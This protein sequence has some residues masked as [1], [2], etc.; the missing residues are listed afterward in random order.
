M[1]FIYFFT[2]PTSAEFGGRVHFSNSVQ[3]EFAL[4]TSQDWIEIA[5]AFKCRPSLKPRALGRTYYPLGFA[6]L[7]IFFRS[8]FFFVLGTINCLR[9]V[10]PS[11]GSASQHSSSIVVPR[12]T[13]VL[14]SWRARGL[15]AVPVPSFTAYD[16]LIK[17]DCD[18]D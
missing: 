8:A 5:A 4:G 2:Y 14:R 7:E 1:S 3:F 10:W 12:R 9:R 13:P 11:F 6:H 16:T 15:R 18:Y 17:D